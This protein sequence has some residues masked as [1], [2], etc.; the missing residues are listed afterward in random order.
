MVDGLTGVHGAAAVGLVAVGHKREGEHA[1]I[2]HQAV[3]VQA[4]KGMVF[5]H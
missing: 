3:A 5:S 2:R 4:A 1:L